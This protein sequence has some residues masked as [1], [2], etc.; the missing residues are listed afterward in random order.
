MFYKW[1]LVFPTTGE[2]LESSR[3]Y[4][5][6]KHASRYLPG[7]LFNHYV[8]IRGEKEPCRNLSIYRE[9]GSL[10]IDI[11]GDVFDKEDYNGNQNERS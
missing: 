9:D 2:I 6:D 4:S 1:R 3:L 10:L 11:Y 5:D 7:Y 8:K